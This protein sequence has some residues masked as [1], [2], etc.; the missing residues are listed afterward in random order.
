[1]DDSDRE[2]IVEKIIYTNE[3]QYYQY[4][5][6][7]GEFR[8]VVYINIRKYFMDFEGNYVPSR[9]GATFPLTLQSLTNLLEGLMEIA[10]KADRDEALNKYFTDLA[11]NNQLES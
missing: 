7:V 1:M 3:E 11:A 8:D 4:R 2:Y 6:T 10:T 9:E 5:L